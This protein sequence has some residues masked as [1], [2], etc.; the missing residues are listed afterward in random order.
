MESRISNGAIFDDLER[1]LPHLKVPPF[2]DAEYLRNGTGYR[3]SFN[4]ILIA[5]Y[6]RRI[7][8]NVISNNIE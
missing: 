5:T 8:I 6:T 3:H 7:L 2:F 4:E 1:P